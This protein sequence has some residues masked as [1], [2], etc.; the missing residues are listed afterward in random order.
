MSSGQINGA[1]AT[2]VS[3]QLPDDKALENAKETEV[4]RLKNGK[5]KVGTSKGSAFN[6]TVRKVFMPKT[7]QREALKATQRQRVAAVETLKGTPNTTTVSLSER[8]ITVA[9]YR[10][11]RNPPP[12][13]PDAVS[14]SLNQQG[15][16]PA[17]VFTAL[18]EASEN[19]HKG[20][21]FKSNQIAGGA[22]FG[23]ILPPQKTAIRVTG[24]VK[25]NPGIKA[26][27][28]FHAN[29]VGHRYIAT[30]GPRSDTASPEYKDYFY[31]ML[32]NESTN[33]VVNLTNGNDVASSVPK[34]KG[35]PIK[36][37]KP[38]LDKQ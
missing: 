17:K 37:G 4:V 28:P 29:K 6:R 1:E 18:Q 2:P 12:P 15:A 38:T 10:S 5:F 25:K 36:G 13:L 31:Q 14:S 23:D 24:T 3:Q 11:L 32:A 9:E 34:S 27:V 30:Q 22:Q 21:Q 33:T 35:T 19:L 26:D 7:Y 8:K 20:K 16:T